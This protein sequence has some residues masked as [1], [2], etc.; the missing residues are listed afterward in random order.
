MRALIAPTVFR[1]QFYLIST[2]HWVSDVSTFVLFKLLKLM[3][4]FNPLR[5]NLFAFIVR[6]SS[7]REPRRQ[8][9]YILDCT[10]EWFGF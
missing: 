2:K 1:E 6:L 9:D 3:E 7:S 5:E 8:D 4:E 10:C